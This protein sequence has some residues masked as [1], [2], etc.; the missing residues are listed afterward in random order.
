MIAFYF[1]GIVDFQDMFTTLIES[2]NKGYKPW[3]CIFDC[4]SKKRQF[5]YYEKNEIIN[6]IKDTLAKNNIVIPES[7]IDFFGQ[8]DKIK[9][10][11][12]FDKRK[13]NV[14]FIQGVWHKYPTW[15]PKVPDKIIHFTWSYDAIQT[16]HRSPYKNK[17][18][19]NIARYKIDEDFLFKN[20]VQ[21]CLYLGNTRLSQFKYNN[22]SNTEKLIKDISSKKVCFIPERWF[23]K[24]E[25]ESTLVN[26][27]QEIIIFLKQ[28]G[29]TV[30]WKRR[31]KGYPF[32]ES[33]T[34]LHKLAIDAKPDIVIERDLF[35]PSAMMTMFKES[36]LI[37]LLGITSSFVDSAYIKNAENI[38]VYNSDQSNNH[39]KF[40]IDTLKQE[41]SGK[42]TIVTSGI[43]EIKEK[44]TSIKDRPSK[45][46][47]Y[48][49]KIEIEADKNIINY[50][51]ENK[52]I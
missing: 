33:H 22:N 51:V 43:D 46:K 3:I 42:V 52:I 12:I 5:Y 15:I 25:D 40:A 45:N 6:F 18:I 11:N 9:F 49:H 23:R 24:E 29:Y 19:L 32:N 35:F 20:K 44:I 27:I 1:T 37:L 2:I 13:P 47:D 34:V 50:L 14:A 38:I 31:E 48:K 21:N 41:L 17:I 16:F 28:A 8:N 39:N 10:E 7:D 36:H 4:L 30:V 26:N